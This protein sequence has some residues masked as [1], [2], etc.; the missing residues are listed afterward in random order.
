MYRRRVE[1]S[2]LNSGLE[3]VFAG[4]YTGSAADMEIFKSK[5]RLFDEISKKLYLIW[6]KVVI[7]GLLSIDLATIS[8]PTDIKLESR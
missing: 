5:R 4:Q 1:V 2:V 6:C 8:P 3:I 7:S